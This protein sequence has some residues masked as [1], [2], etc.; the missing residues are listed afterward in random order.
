ML[1]TPRCEVW[2]DPIAHSRSPELHR[3]AYRVLDL[4][5]EYDRRRVTESRFTSELN[6]LGPRFRGLSVTMPLKSA[7]YRAASRRDRR[8]QLTG[9]VNTLALSARGAHGFNTDIGGLVQALKDEGMD[10]LDHVRIVGAGATATSALVA[11]AEMGATRIDVVARRPDATHHLIALGETLGVQVEARSF[12]SRSD[13]AVELTIATLPG[14]APL[15]DAHTDAL[16]ATGGTLFDV[17][18]G[19]WPTTLA[20]A[21]QR[22]DA[23]AIS[24]LGMLLHQ[25]LLQVRAFTTGDIE[26]PIADEPAVL[27]AMRAALVGD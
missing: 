27:A 16:A 6:S 9:A 19:Q 13:S 24:G 11:A 18:Y 10:A 2:G 22:N 15:S 26:E 12:D 1:V 25:A 21:W 23:I 17:V 4:E 8:A 14:D 7:A 20:A 3:A 5:W